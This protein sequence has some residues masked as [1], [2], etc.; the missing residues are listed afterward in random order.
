MS[1]PAP[2]VRSIGE[3]REAPAVHTEEPDMPRYLLSVHV[4]ADDHPQQMSAEDQQRGFQRVADLERDMRAADALVMSARLEG[5]DSAFV[6]RASNGRAVTTDG[7]YVEAKELI[8]GFYLIEAPDREAAAEWAS[9]TS[10]AIGM[11]IEVRPLWA[12]AGDSEPGQPA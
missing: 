6:V 10:A 2:P 11:P 12:S 4:G 7:P 9:R 8:G 5:P 1:I 3:R